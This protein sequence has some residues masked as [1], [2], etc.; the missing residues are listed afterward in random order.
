[1]P[2]DEDNGAYQFQDPQDG[3]NLPS[4][5]WRKPLG[6]QRDLRGHPQLEFVV[7]DFQERQQFSSHDS[8]ITIVDQGIRELERSTTDGDIA[9]P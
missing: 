3:I 9:I 1:M 8:D 5:V 6:S 7:C 2:E 4:L